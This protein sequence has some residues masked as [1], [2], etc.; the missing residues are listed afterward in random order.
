[1]GNVHRAIIRNG[2]EIH[3]QS[4]IRG[5]RIDWKR[6]LHLARVRHANIHA[7]KGIRLGGDIAGD[8]WSIRNEM[9]IRARSLSIGGGIGTNATITVARRTVSR[10]A[11]A[12][13]KSHCPKAEQ[14]SSY[15][16]EPHHDFL[17]SEGGGNP[18]AVPLGIQGKRR[19]DGTE[20]LTEQ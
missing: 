20:A 18:R 15:E 13:D 2:G 19:H 6:G 9:R 8:T 10:A 16:R 5:A 7:R 14:S 3:G 17:S 4:V 1:M 11:A 12:G